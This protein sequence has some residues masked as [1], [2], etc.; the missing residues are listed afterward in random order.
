METSQISPIGR[1]GHVGHAS[2]RRGGRASTWG[3]ISEFRRRP[4][5]AAQT[6]RSRGKQGAAPRGG[7]RQFFA[8]GET[9]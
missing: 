9:S 3:A 6:L 7:E 2:L 1:A 5:L 4:D 8:F